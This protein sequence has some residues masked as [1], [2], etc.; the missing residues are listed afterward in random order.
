MSAIINIII[1]PTCQRT[2]TS[3]CTFSHFHCDPELL[4]CLSL[5]LGE[6]R[7]LLTEY[8]ASVPLRINK[9]N[10]HHCSWFALS[11]LLSFYFHEVLQHLNTFM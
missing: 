5:V 6:P 9:Q 1:S 2:L 4:I 7:R 3:T 11:I 10:H 8:S